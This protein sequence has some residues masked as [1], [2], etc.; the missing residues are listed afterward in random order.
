MADRCRRSPQP[1]LPL[2]LLLLAAGAADLHDYTYSGDKAEASRETLPGTMSSG[3]GDLA[4]GASRSAE[5]REEPRWCSWKCRTGVRGNNYSYQKEKAQRRIPL[6]KLVM[7]Q[8]YRNVPDWPQL[9]NTGV[10][11][12]QELMKKDQ[13]TFKRLVN[14]HYV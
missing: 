14:S 3:C 7:G 4:G 10:S 2:S 8:D 5:R 9:F 13:I 12:Y 6:V 1:R 11:H